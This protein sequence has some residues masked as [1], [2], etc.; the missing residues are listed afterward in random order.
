MPMTALLRNLSKLATLGLLDDELNKFIRP[1]FFLIFLNFRECVDLV[2]SKI[3]NQEA[4]QKARIHPIAVLLASSVYKSGHGIKGKL[5]WEVN[6][7]VK[8]A[9]EQCFIL[10]FK[11]VQP[12]GQRF[13]LAMDVSG[14]LEFWIKSFSFNL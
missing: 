1:S 9:L 8:K 3:L 6:D 5:K 14:K 4:L 11:N 2:I 12:T 7:R 10:A 13:C